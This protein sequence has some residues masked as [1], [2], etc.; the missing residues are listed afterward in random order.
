MASNASIA[1]CS[2]FEHSLLYRLC[3]RAREGSPTES[4]TICIAIL[5][6]CTRIPSMSSNMSSI[7]FNSLH[8]VML[9]VRGGG[10]HRQR[11]GFPLVVLARK[12]K[13]LP[14]LSKH[15]LVLIV[16]DGR[17]ANT[18][19]VCHNASFND[20]ICGNYSNSVPRVIYV[21]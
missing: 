19:F 13:T 16:S 2:D 20:E 17:R 10:V 15:C 1:L 14:S 11:V 6:E 7:R 4:T 21:D 12:K 3:M 9:C 5:A 8:G 18:L